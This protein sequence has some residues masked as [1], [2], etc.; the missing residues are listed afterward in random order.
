M[1]LATGSRCCAP[2]GSSRRPPRRRS[3]T[4]PPTCSSPRSG[5]ARDELR[6][7]APRARRRA[8]RRLQ[9]PRS[10]RR[11][12]PAGVG[13]TGDARPAAGDLRGRRVRRRGPA[14]ASRWRSTSSR[15]WAPTRMSS[16]ASTRRAIDSEELR[17]ANDGQDATLLAR[18]GAQRSS[19]RASTTAPPRAPARAPH[20]RRR[21]RARALLRP[22]Q[23]REPAPPR[24]LGR[25]RARPP[26]NQSFLQVRGESRQRERDAEDATRSAA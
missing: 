18:E 16:S 6:R 11:S 3:T 17:A 25:G 24:G 26:L 4:T 12:A 13:S 23:R 14:G 20:A 15:S 10:S 19:G 5:L 9:D 22:A 2:A 1:T 7:G 21:P 8:L